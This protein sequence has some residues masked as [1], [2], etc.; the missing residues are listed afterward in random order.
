M[1]QGY[2]SFDIRTRRCQAHWPR[3][4]VAAEYNMRAFL[5]TLL[6]VISLALC[7]LL[8][9]QWV[10]E[11]RLRQTVQEL[12]DTVQDKKEAIQNLEGLVKRADQEN[13]RLE[14]IR[15]TLSDTV[16][17]NQ[18]DIAR[19]SKELSQAMA[20]AERQQKQIDAY[21][22]ALGQANANIQRQN[23]TITQQNEQMKKLAEERNEV[24][25]KYN[26]VV[27]EFNALVQKWNE[28]QS[29]LAAAATNAPAKK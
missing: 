8:A 5:V 3:G 28:Q 27:E 18:V 10:R 9:F 1:G 12:T 7:G 15:K 22:E 21:K 20:E 25:V 19:L 2:W 23:E 16:K 24:V 14:G 6:M 13:A 29:A 17:S 4:G 11:V 26:K